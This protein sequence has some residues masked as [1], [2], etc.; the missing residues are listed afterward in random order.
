MRLNRM[1]LD[2][3]LTLTAFRPLARLAPGEV[4]VLMY[5]SVSV[6]AEPGVKPYYRITTTPTRFAEQM[7]WLAAAGYRG[8]SL[9]TALTARTRNA[10][11]TERLVAIT[12]DDGFRDFH[13]A[14]WPALHKHGFTATMYL[15]TAFIADERQIFRGRECLTW[16]EIRELRQHGIRFGSHT[17]T[18]P[19]LYD[20]SWADI[21]LELK[22]SRTDLQDALGETITSFAYPFAFPQ[23][24]R[25]YTD[26]FRAV[27]ME[28]GYQSCAT[29]IIGGLTM[30]A[31]WLCVKRLPVNQ[32]DDRAFFLAKLSGA[33]DWYGRVQFGYR[34]LQRWRGISRR[35]VAYN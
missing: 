15:P 32:C 26:R 6:D 19:R 7:E 13:T 28:A 2:R 5:H 30:E 3:S 34:L 17:V 24:D 22:R 4:S 33:Y 1:R 21:E 35:P 11:G 10:A 9:E 23:E 12:F 27:L 31:D 29:T 14:A 16:A 20:L 25:N 18:H 8:V